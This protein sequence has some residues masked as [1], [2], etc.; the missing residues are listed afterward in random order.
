MGFPSFLSK[1]VY[2]WP[3]YEDA[4]SKSSLEVV[5][6]SSVAFMPIGWVKS[7]SR[8]GNAKGLYNK[9]I[10]K[11]IHMKYIWEMLNSLLYSWI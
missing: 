4:V 10:Y 7:L 2:I 9:S 5:G 1:T 8:T 3:V 11:I 6:S